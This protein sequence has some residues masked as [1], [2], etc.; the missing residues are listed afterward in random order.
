MSSFHLKVDTNLRRMVMSQNGCVSTEFLRV[1]IFSNDSVRAVL[2][3]HSDFLERYMGQKV[4]A[5]A[6]QSSSQNNSI[7][8]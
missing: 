4:A 6:P 1:P 5:V 2:K 8:E 7:Q 3:R